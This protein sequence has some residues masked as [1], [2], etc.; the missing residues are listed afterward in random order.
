MNNL[1]LVYNNQG[2]YD[3]AE[4]LHIKTLEIRRRVLGEEHPETL[5]SMNNLALVY[6][7]QGRCEEAEQLHIKTLELAR[8]VLGEEHPGALRSMK[9]LLELY[10]VWGK[11]EKAEEWRRKL[12]SGKDL[13]AEETEDREQRTAEIEE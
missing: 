11:P 6:G 2:R 3:E 12:R 4:Q 13:E 5:T 9:N 10:E 7:R 1:A 8:H